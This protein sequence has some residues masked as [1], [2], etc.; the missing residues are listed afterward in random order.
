MITLE[1]LPKK[2]VEM[3]MQRLADEQAEYYFYISASAWARLN[4]Y[5]NIAKYFT[6][7][8]H[9]EE[10]HFKTWVKF[11]SDW[12]VQIVFPAIKDPISN[13]ANIQDILEQQYKMEVELGKR[14]ESDALV[15]FSVSQIV[16]KKMQDFI[17]IQ[18]YSVIEVSN[19]I[20]KLQGYLQTDPDLRSFDKEEFGQYENYY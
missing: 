6:V 19:I 18:N 3:I 15:M 12:N 2:A 10:Y 7:E 1:T 9:G 4:G 5:D 16:F 14:Y 20:T 11:L 17:D 13:F 8:S